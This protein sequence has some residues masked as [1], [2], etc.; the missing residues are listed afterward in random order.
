MGSV[1]FILMKIEDP[2]CVSLYRDKELEV[3][4]E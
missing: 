3:G 1:E 2:V 4:C